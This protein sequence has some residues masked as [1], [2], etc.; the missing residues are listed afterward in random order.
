[1]FSF[2]N[3]ILSLNIGRPGLDTVVDVSFF[4]LLCSLFINGAF[5]EGQNY[6]YYGAFFL[7][8]GATLVKLMI[9]LKSAE[10]IIL[11]TFTLWYGSFLVLSLTSMLWATYPD[12]SMLVISR[13][14]QSTVITFCM[15]QNY[16]TRS[17]LM[18]CINLFTWAGAYATAFVFINTPFSQWFSGGFGSGAAKLNPNTIG[19]IFTLCVLVSFY[20]AFYCKK[21]YC[22][23]LTF[24]QLFAV[25]LTSSRKSLI[26]SIIGLMMLII[27]RSRRRTLIWRILAALGLFVIVYFI[28]MTVPELYSA[29]GI[30]IESMLNHLSN[31]GGDYSMSLRQTFIDNAR[32][33][34][35]EKPLLG[36]GIN[37]FIVQMSLRN[38]VANY[39][40]NNYY[41]M[42]A[43]LGIVGFSLF[44]SYYFYMLNELLKIWRKSNGSLVKLMIAW[45]VVIMICEYGLVTYYALYIHVTL[46][47]AFLFICAYGQED[48]MSSGV[49]SYLKYENG[50]FN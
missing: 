33:M 50:I 49:P 9:R 48:D 2:K 24:F 21:K 3:G 45:I 29:V 32:D 30:R 6:F 11:P 46:C 22:Y 27:M 10:T 8:F 4:L 42:L 31:D 12:S 20:L 17:G 38:G 23:V 41:E 44:Y 16:A 15:A 25:I 19:M 35:F 26:A 28:I 47:Y 39:A 1:M 36:Y 5:M 40:H 37:N 14:I 7:F 34:F 18:K 13:L 43:D